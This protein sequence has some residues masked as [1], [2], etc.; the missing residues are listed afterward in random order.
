MTARV[1]VAV[2]AAAVRTRRLLLASATARRPRFWASVRGPAG[3]PPTRERTH[4]G[5]VGRHGGGGVA[6]AAVRMW[7]LLV[8]SATARRPRFWASV[9][10]PAAALPPT[11]KRTHDAEGG[12]GG[13]VEKG[14]CCG[15]PDAAVA[16]AVCPHITASC[17]WSPK[18]GGLV[19]PRVHK[20]Y[21]GHWFPWPWRPS[22]SVPTGAHLPVAPIVIVEAEGKLTSVMSVPPPPAIFVHMQVGAGVRY[23]DGGDASV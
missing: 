3:A 6:A 8:A 21:G 23:H 17:T 12:S 19:H 7:R 18:C 2:A 4:D 5:E 10:G 16:A 13:E 9:R 15:C 11:G 20:R 22:P 1:V 14:G